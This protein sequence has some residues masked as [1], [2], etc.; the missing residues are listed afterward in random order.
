MEEG[1]G[2]FLLKDMFN[3]WANKTKLAQ[4][5]YTETVVFQNHFSSLIGT[6]KLSKIDEIISLELDS[7]INSVTRTNYCAMRQT[8][9]IDSTG[10]HDYYF[11][12]ILHSGDMM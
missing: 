5:H 10:K 11:A 12:L 3:L 4:N 8:S 9:T 2:L 7:K 1:G 6:T